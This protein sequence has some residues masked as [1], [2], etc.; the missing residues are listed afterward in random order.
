M[1]LLDR[2]RRPGEETLAAPTIA[3]FFSETLLD[4]EEVMDA[5]KVTELVYR[6]LVSAENCVRERLNEAQSDTLNEQIIQAVGARR[7]NLDT[8]LSNL[9]LDDTIKE[10]IDRSISPRLPAGDV[11]MDRGYGQQLIKK[12]KFRGSGGLRLEVPAENYYTVVI[13]EE[14]ITDDPDKPPFY[15][16]VIE[17]E[18]WKRQV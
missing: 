18:E 9:A 5:R 6:S 7:W 12:I 14:H 3:R 15:R 4:A 8:W 1:L 11:P 2:Q 13:S 10:E 17:T 16:I